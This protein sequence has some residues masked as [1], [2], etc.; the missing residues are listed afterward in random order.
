MN[1]GGYTS[2]PLLDGVSVFVHDTGA[3]SSRYRLPQY[4]VDGEEI[5]LFLATASG[6]LNLHTGAFVVNGVYR[7]MHASSIG[8]QSAYQCDLTG[9]NRY[10]CV[11]IEA[12]QKWLIL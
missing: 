3:N 10:K 4:P 11:F 9:V 2:W 5:E 6:A 12:T 7:Q 8:K 1:P